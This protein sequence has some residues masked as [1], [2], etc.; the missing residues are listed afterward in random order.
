MP[1]ENRVRASFVDLSAAGS[2]VTATYCDDVFLA[3]AR[4]RA[5]ALGEEL[6]QGD[7]LFAVGSAAFEAKGTGLAV[8]ALW[9]HSPCPPVTAP[10]P[11][12]KRVVRANAAPDLTFADGKMHA[13]LDLGTDVS[14][15]VYVGRLDGTAAV[16]EH[17]HP[18][19]WEI[20]CAVEAAGTFTLDGKPSRLA[21]RG[22]VTVPPNTKH[23]WQP[24][25]GS[26]LVAIQLYS[27]PGPEQRFRALAAA[28]RDAGAP[29]AAANKP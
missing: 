5:S 21:A 26:R 23:A 25:E 19:S 14:P 4:G 13:R 29:D 11:L 12:V 6:E 20:L 7:V 15:N 8:V 22:I 3:V 9:S 28:A 2:P 1:S 10:P 16:P 24:D 27:P 17:T 18:T